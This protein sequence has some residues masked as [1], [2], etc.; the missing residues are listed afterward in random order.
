MEEFVPMKN[1]ISILISLA[2]LLCALPAMAESYDDALD[3]AF[4]A[5]RERSYRL[6]SLCRTWRPARS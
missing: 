2:L 4:E 5:G 6:I 1:L 3:A